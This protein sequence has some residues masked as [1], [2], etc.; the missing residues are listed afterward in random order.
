MTVPVQ[1]K[2]YHIVHID[3]LQS[4]IA[5]GHLWCDAIVVK[6]APPG[7]VIGMG[8]IKQRRLNKLTLTSYPDLRV[9]NCVPFYF[10]P[11]SIMLYLIHKRNS[12][13][14]YSGGQE[15]IVHLQADLYTSVNWAQQTSKRWAFTLSNAGEYGFE[16]LCNPLE[17][18]KLD[19]AA[20]QA[21]SWSD[22]LIKRGKQAEFLIEH[23]FPWH[24][25]ECIGVCSRATHQEVV[26]V[27][28]A[29]APHPPV[30]IKPEWYYD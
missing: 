14:A 15:P 25:V 30:A 26:N 23:S 22:P 29:T 20:I 27:L 21:N 28:S 8:N 11:R 24:L 13:L 3:R 1:P 4:I 17:L 12:E 10:C 2:I 19:W 5:D 9:G 7:T 6:R 16:D 18:N